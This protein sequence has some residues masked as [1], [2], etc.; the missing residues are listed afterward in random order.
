M[1]RR[2]YALDAEYVPLSVAATVAYFHLAESRRVTEPEEGAAQLVARAAM[3]LCQI[4]EIHVMGEHETVSPMSPGEVE[5]RLCRPLHAR[6][7][8]DLDGFL[9]RRGDLRAAIKALAG[10]AGPLIN[11]RD[12]GADHGLR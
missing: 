6:R 3:A 12:L 4:A 11:R 8:P 7:T 2:H 10:R 1:D 5:E 9:I